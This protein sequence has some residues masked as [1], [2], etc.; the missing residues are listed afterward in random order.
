MYNWFSFPYEKDDKN[1]HGKYMY[2]VGGFFS[3]DEGCPGWGTS[4]VKRIKAIGDCVGHI[5]VEYDD[6]TENKIP[7]IFGY[8]MWYHSIWNERPAPFFG[9]NKD[10]ELIAALKLSLAVKGG[11]EGDKYGV[12]RIQ[13]DDKDI[14]S[15]Y[16]ASNPEKEGSCVFVGGYICDADEEASVALSQRS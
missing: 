16:V 5:V 4:D 11:W 10:E 7:L 14:K 1:L 6:G 9:E 15:I 2:A 13:I 3:P 8:T 12:I